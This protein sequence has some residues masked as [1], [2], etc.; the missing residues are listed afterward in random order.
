MYKQCLLPMLLPGRCF[1]CPFTTL[2][3]SDYTL[4]HSLSTIQCWALAP[5]QFVGQRNTG[6]LHEDSKNQKRG[7]SETSPRGIEP[8]R[9]YYQPSHKVWTQARWT[10]TNL[11]RSSFFFRL[12]NCYESHVESPY[13]RSTYE[14]QAEMRLVVQG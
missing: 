14:E 5:S 4:Q 1:G 3:T 7:F 10:T 11:W 9:S 13:L 2:S 12:Q 8:S 6:P